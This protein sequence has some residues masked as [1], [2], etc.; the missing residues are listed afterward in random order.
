MSE[1]LDKQVNAQ[2]ENLNTSGVHTSSRKPTKKCAMKMKVE[3]KKKRQAPKIFLLHFCYIFVT[4]L[5]YFC[6][7]IHTLKVLCVWHFKRGRMSEC[8]KTRNGWYLGLVAPISSIVWLQILC[9]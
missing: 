2:K 5:L 4:F 1:L 3:I 6:Y 7:L 8:H 9:N